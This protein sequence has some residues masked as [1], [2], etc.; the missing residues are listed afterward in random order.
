[1]RVRLHGNMARIEVP[2]KDIERLASDEIRR[3]VYES[4]RELGF[5]FV[6]LD[7]RGYRMG[8]MNETLW[9]GGRF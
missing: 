9:T 1:E 2:E 8:S 5:A 4:F 3:K 6:T 7:M